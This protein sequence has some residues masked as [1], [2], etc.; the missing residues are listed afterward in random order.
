M[1]IVG[2]T[3]HRYDLP[4]RHPIGLSRGLLTTR[5]GIILTLTTSFGLVGRGEVAPLPGFSAESFA[6]AE[7]GVRSLAEEIVGRTVPVDPDEA[8][9]WSDRVARWVWRLGLPA[10]AMTGLQA[11]IVDLVAA[12]RRETPAQTLHPDAGVRGARE[13]A[14]LG[15][16]RTTCSRMR[17]GCGPA[18]FAP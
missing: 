4:L 3:A 2:L 12:H 8:G 1:R 7:A 16:S 9:M 11:A 18:G 6:E 14:A 17:R 10:S 5:T 15:G 13:R